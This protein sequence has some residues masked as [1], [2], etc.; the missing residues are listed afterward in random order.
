MDICQRCGAQLRLAVGG[1]EEGLWV[2]GAGGEVCDSAGAPHQP[3]LGQPSGSSWIGEV[4]LRA[5]GAWHLPRET[6]ARLI[7]I[8]LLILAAYPLGGWIAGVMG[9][10]GELWLNAAVA[11]LGLA[12]G[13]AAA[14][15][16]RR[17]E[18]LLGWWQ[19]R[20]ARRRYGGHD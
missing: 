15:A 6:K 8:V 9:A 16:D 20:W 4:R 11:V 3:V 5:A 13:V 10:H 1:C 17:I 14:V 18:A 19:R 12:L 7:T 2:D